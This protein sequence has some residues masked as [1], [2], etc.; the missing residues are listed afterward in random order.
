MK[1]PKLVDRPEFVFR[2]DCLEFLERRNRRPGARFGVESVRSPLFG[3]EQPIVRWNVVVRPAHF[4][5]GDASDFGLFCGGRRDDGPWPMRFFFDV[6]IS[7]LALGG[8]WIVATVEPHQQA[9]MLAEAK[10][11]VA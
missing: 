10:Q 7:L 9:R 1:I 5:P 8:W 3:I 2:Q 4:Y 6:E 11:L